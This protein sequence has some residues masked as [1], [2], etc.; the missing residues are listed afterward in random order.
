[1]EIKIEFIVYPGVRG[2][3]TQAWETGKGI[4]E[5]EK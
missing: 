5:K 3:F 4:R 1:M 2:G